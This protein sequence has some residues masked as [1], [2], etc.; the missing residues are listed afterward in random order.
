MRCN[1]LYLLSIVLILGCTG[2]ELTAATY[3]VNHIPDNNTLNVTIGLKCANMQ[4]LINYEIFDNYTQSNI[5]E[6]TINMPNIIV[7]DN[8]EYFTLSINTT[9]TQLDPYNYYKVKI[10][11]PDNVYVSQ[12]FYAEM[13][14]NKCDLI[15]KTGP[16]RGFI[17][18]YYYNQTTR[19][20]EEFTYGGCRGIVPFDTLQECE[21]NCII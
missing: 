9:G 21:N 16:C 15:P 19:T 11:L 17:Q 12:S 1:L 3:D 6:G 13:P 14:E 5:L 8:Y 10:K 2:C 20:C 18:K 4:G 7:G